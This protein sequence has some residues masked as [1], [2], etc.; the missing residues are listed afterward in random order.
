MHA[1][2]ASARAS[3]HAAIQFSKQLVWL[4]SLGQRVAVSA[5]STEDLIVNLEM[6]ANPGSNRFLSHVSMTSAWDQSALMRFGQSFFTQADQQHPAI[7]SN[8]FV[9]LFLRELGG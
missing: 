4:Q 8:N 7:E 5:M 9:C 2:A 1:S 6:C 3:G